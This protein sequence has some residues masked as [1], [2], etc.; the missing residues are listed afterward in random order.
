MC[1]PTGNGWGESRE[2]M[3]N[4]AETQQVLSKSGN[5]IVERQIP[6][7]TDRVTV[8]TRVTSPGAGHRHARGG[9]YIRPDRAAPAR[10]P[11]RPLST[12]A[13]VEGPSPTP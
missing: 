10:R 1:R 7:E 4:L 8:E 12:L 13:R 5:P 3:Q 2:Y 9:G 11:P 6:L